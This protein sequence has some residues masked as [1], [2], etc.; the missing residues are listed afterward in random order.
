VL[1]HVEDTDRDHRFCAT[2]LLTELVYP[3]VLDPVFARVFDDDALV[4][5]AARAAA[6]AFAELYAQ[7][8]VERFELVAMDGAEN[9]ER[10]ILAIEAI[11]ETRVALAI[12]ALVRLLGD[13]NGEIRV[14]VRSALTMIAR[15]DF[16]VSSEKWETW[17]AQNKDRH[18]LEWLIDALMNEHAALRAAASEELKTT[19]KEY[20]GYYDDLPKKEREKAQELYRAWWEREGK[21][22]FA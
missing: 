13:P 1:S 3:D 20:F 15:Q 14:A 21:L 19:T 16:G 10:R 17:W 6:R 12:P 22:R 11:G 2:Y 9:S 5:R 4:R 8:I 7:S 18:R